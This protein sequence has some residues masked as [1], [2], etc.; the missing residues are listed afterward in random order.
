M[1]RW[2]VVGVWLVGGSV[3][4]LTV[5]GCGMRLWSGQDT[6]AAALV[7]SGEKQEQDA[8][9]EYSL[10]P[11]QGLV[12]GGLN[13][14]RPFSPNLWIEDPESTG[15]HTPLIL[16]DIPWDPHAALSVEVPE[17]SWASVPGDKHNRDPFF[18]GR[19]IGGKQNWTMR[20]PSLARPTW[21]A[22]A[23]GGFELDNQ[24]E[25]GYVQRFKVIPRDRMIEIRFG[26]TNN[27][28][29]PLKDLRCQLCTRSH[30]VKGFSER[31]P[32]SSKMFSDG[33][34]V[35][36][37]AAGQD[38]SWLEPHRD[39]KTG[40]FDQSCFFLA[41][42]KGYEPREY[43]TGHLRRGNVMWLARAVDIP[44]I[45]KEDTAT[46]SRYLV[47]YSPF[48]R[49]VFYNCLTPCFH[50]DPRMKHIEPGETRWTIS[51][52]I[53]FEGDIGEFFTALAELHGQLKREEGILVE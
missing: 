33:Q 29:K 7:E 45:A 11:I 52:L 50:A 1:K 43:R 19:P 8:M 20:Y 3:F 12:A 39:R 17:Y 2:A 6:R 25:G 35:S 10:E 40:R 23:D 18:Y 28:D 44:A 27:S 16:T 15:R 53:L 30:Q 4:V 42:V 14:V 36:W 48:G 49:N 41:P 9:I 38:L 26:I 22:R 32:T 34:V 51:Y 5:N 46:K 47:V 21:Q 37:D 31:W 13:R 24:L